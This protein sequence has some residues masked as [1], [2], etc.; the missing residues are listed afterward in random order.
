[1]T[2]A[3]LNLL[4]RRYT[5]AQSASGRLLL[6]AELLAR[7]LF[8]AALTRGPELLKRG[9]D[10]TFSLLALILLIPLFALI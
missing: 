4:S 2:G 10:I 5:L 7:E 8:W 6:S 1:M 3:E 9:V